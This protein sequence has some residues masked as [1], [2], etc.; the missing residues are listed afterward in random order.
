MKKY[1]HLSILAVLAISCTP[2]KS[3]IT[4]PHSTQGTVVDEYFGTPVADPYRWLEDDQSEETKAWVKAQNEVT[5]AY[6][7]KIPLRQELKER[8]TQLWDYPTS[9]IP[10]KKGDLYFISCNTGKQ[11]QSVIYV[12]ENLEDT[13]RVLLDPNTLSSDGTIALAATAVSEDQKYFAY[14]ISK[15]GSDWREIF[16]KNIETGEQLKD[17][18]LWAKFSSITWY[19][20]GFFYS[21]YPAPKDGQQLKG[22]NHYSKVYYHKLGTSQSEDMLI[23]ENPD[24]PGWGFSVAKMEDN[25]DYLILYTTEST[26]GN[27]LSI[28]QLKNLKK[29]PL[30]IVK[31]FDKDF[32][33]I[34]Y[35]ENKLYVITNYKAPKYRL[36]SI[37]PKKPQEKYWETVIPE[38]EE[39]LLGVQHTGGVLFASYLKDALSMVVQYDEQGR[40]IRTVDFPILGNVSGFSGD[41]NEKNP[42]YSITSFTTPANI[43]RYNIETGK[44]TLFQKSKVQFDQEAYESKQIF[45]TSKDGTKVP[46]FIVHKKGIKL[47]GNNPTLLYGY[48]GFNSSMKPSFSPLRIAFL[49]RGGVYALANIRGGGEYGE[50]WHRSGT[51]MQ[52][53]NVFDDFIAAGEYLIETG[54]TS[55]QKLAIMG[56]SN[57]GLLVGACMT[58]R[59]DLFRVALPAVGV[60]D[61]LRYHKF[62]I[63]HYW[64]TDYG[65]SEDSKEMFE[66][67][68]AYSPVHNVKEGV[69][70]P[71]TMITTADHD[72]RVVPAHSFKFAAELQT[73]HKGTRPMLIRIST[74]AGHGAGKPK[75]MV[76]DEYADI[77]AFIFENVK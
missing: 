10:S 56:G 26:S 22:S 70:Y 60:L 6:L 64:A 14:A 55:K 20:D 17:H 73:K 50:Q 38:Q 57:G 59:P 5:F 41:K 66:Y 21:R 44:S 53:Q 7:D 36:I 15:S 65:T 43:Y 72:D 45:Y 33:V 76:I 34:A 4:Y 18:I 42:F 58:Q 61:M 39:T 51:L 37:D 52:K 9:S 71:A 63:G 49:E 11:N 68:R 29:K 46:L 27:A 69:E 54:Y 19:K 77:W 1:I 12:K 3:N 74:K 48:G 28:I 24:Q 8:M 75:S 62:T 40:K 13:G 23:H 2:K 30:E 35:V 25:D 16:V 31:N 67:L 47:D 32:S